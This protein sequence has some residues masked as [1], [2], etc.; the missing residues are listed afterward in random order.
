VGRARVLQVLADTDDVD[1]GRFALELHGRLAERG[2]EVRTLALGPGRRGGLEAVLPVM[3]PSRRSI[4]AHT[5]LRREQ[6]WA[7]VV[8]LRGERPALVAALANR[9]GAPPTVLALAGDAH[10]WAAGPV[11][12][13]VH[14]L[15]QQGLAAVVTADPAATAGLATALGAD[16]GDVHDI[17]YGVDVRPPVTTPAARRVARELLGLPADGVVARC[18][19]TEPDDGADLARRAAARAGVV[20]VTPGS[21][22]PEVEAAAADV[23][24]LPTRRSAGP[25]LGLLAAARDGDALVAPAAGALAGLVDDTTGRVCGPD[26]DAVVAA[27]A[28]LMA[29]PHA[30]AAA[31]AAASERVRRSYGLDDVADAWA[32]LLAVAAARPGA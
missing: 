15:V 29:D 3:S 10:R 20:L 31:G 23:A 19:G 9:A 2:L 11:P 24:V 26:E 7:D 21:G 17:P 12:S 25:P 5:Q 8:V 18:V 27:L 30:V 4:A 16:P 1:D 22:D 14:R 32:D 6:R 28:D 13:R